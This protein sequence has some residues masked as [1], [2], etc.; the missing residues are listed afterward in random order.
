MLSILRL[1]QTKAI[2]HAYVDRVTIPS[3]KISIEGAVYTRNLALVRQAVERDGDHALLD[4]YFVHVED[5]AS[6]G[7]D[8]DV[9]LLEYLLANQDQLGCP[10]VEDTIH[11]DKYNP[12]ILEVLCRYH[13]N[14]NW[15]YENVTDMLHEAMFSD[16]GEP[17][18]RVWMEYLTNYDAHSRCVIL[19]WC[20]KYG[21]VE[22]TTDLM[23]VCSDPESMRKLYE[24]SL[25]NDNPAVMQ[26]LVEH[27]YF[28]PC[29][30]ELF[31]TNRDTLATWF[32]SN[33]FTPKRKE[34]LNL[35]MHHHAPFLRNEFQHVL[36]VINDPE[37]NEGRDAVLD[38]TDENK[39]H[40]LFTWM[41]RYDCCRHADRTQLAEF[42]NQH[43]SEKDRA[44]LLYVKTHRRWPPGH[45]THGG[46]FRYLQDL[47]DLLET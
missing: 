13:S 41:A 6:M 37:L 25:K 19:H 3:S 20:S 27:N 21:S 7:R 33:E 34:T 35:W 15:G 12:R 46:S 4:D 16:G 22:F 29:Q 43:I 30:E 5:I 26:F 9:E 8:E 1:P 40:E 24:L 23:K 38:T 39:V 36:W 28:I 18:A 10:W 31:K 42:V 44:T 47:I 14:W 17:F 11:C 32:L 2:F 45:H